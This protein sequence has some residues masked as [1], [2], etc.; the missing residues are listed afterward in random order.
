MST[1]QYATPQAL[2]A[3][4]TDRLRS[5]AVAHGAQLNDL[6]RQFAYD[7]F[8]AR[9]FEDDPE[10]WVLKGATAMLARLGPGSRHTL[11]V[12]LYRSAGTLDEAEEA[13]R[14]SAALDLGDYFRFE[15]APGR[16]V[17]GPVAT[18]Q[19]TVTAYLG[20]TVFAS[21]PVDL[22]TDLNMT[23]PPDVI[24]PLVDVDIPG[25]TPSRYR[26]Y[27]VVDHIADKVCAIHELHERVEGPPQPSTR[28][29]DLADLSTFARTAVVEADALATAL[30]SEAARRRLT[31]PAQV[32][33]PTDRGWRAGYARVARDAPALVDRDIMAAVDTVC[34]FIDP[35]LD[36]SAAGRWDP[37]R[38]TWINAG[39]SA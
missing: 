2:R 10:R 16:P 35:V 12:D 3:A 30:R 14:A 11:D 5:V 23:A 27:P 19:L 29:R 36:G 24:G 20:A 7:R 1:P 15:I 26:V 9:V 34:R 39:D 4:V 32:T 31:L 18:R 13:L 22:V 33:V 17:A 28:Y 38:L 25:I 37:H 21:F 6:L 8:L